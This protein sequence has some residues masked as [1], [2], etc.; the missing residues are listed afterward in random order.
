MVRLLKH[1][2]N[3]SW[4]AM[5]CGDCGDPCARAAGAADVMMRSNQLPA[6][7]QIDRSMLYQRAVSMPRMSHL[8]TWKTMSP[9]MLQPADPDKRTI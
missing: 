1:L 8:E 9:E 4:G 3:D 2:F 5:R 6:N 7:G